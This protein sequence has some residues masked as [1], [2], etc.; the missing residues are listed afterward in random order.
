MRSLVLPLAVVLVLTGCSNLGDLF[1]AHAD[2]AATAAGQELPAT[3]VAEIVAQARGTQADMPMA[4]FVANL[5]VD[6]TLFSQRVARDGSFGVDSAMVL[7]A[8]WPQI[9]EQ[10][11]AAWRDTIL[12]HRAA[13][14]TAALANSIWEAGDQRVFQHILVTP[15]GATAADTARAQR[16]IEDVLSRVRGGASFAAQAERLNPDA[17]KDDGGFLPPSPRGAFVP[18]F[19][20]VAWTLDPGTISDVVQS[21]F[22][23]H[24]IRRPPLG[25][26]LERLRA[27]ALQR[28]TA[29]Q[30]SIFFVQLD[31]GSGLKIRDGAAS[32]ARTALGD[33]FGSLKSSKVLADLDGDDMTVGMFSKWMTSLNAGQ[34]N[35]VKE[36][37]DSSLNGFIEAIARQ[38]LLLRSADSAGIELPNGMWA[39]LQLSLN[40]SVSQLTTAMALNSPEVTDST[41]SLADREAAAAEKVEAY[42]DQLIS[43]QAQFQP[44]PGSLGASLRRT[45]RSKL[46]RAGLSRSVEL[47][48]ARGRADSAA[49]ALQAPAQP[50]AIQPAPGGPPIPQPGQ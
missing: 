29:R 9:T 23:F 13:P 33:V 25:E 31:E 35:Q 30:D 4:E 46:N 41:K 50:G 48:V 16:E 43:G 44:L 14:D 15:K 38:E 7:D 19:D 17:T 24:L 18:E 8:M 49:R 6:L 10:R 2:V 21:A 42:F 36:L 12:A 32:A 11:I 40:A 5:W 34:I 47:A 39:A 28:E 1:S 22:G 27:Y 37:P 20:A 26:V 45:M 3:R